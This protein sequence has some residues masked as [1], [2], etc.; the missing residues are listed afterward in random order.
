MS[1]IVN[2]R[3]FS[4]YPILAMCYIGHFY[5]NFDLRFH[6]FVSKGHFPAYNVFHTRFYYR[7]FILGSPSARLQCCDTRH[8]GITVSKCH[9]VFGTSI[10]TKIPY[11]THMC[12]N[13]RVPLGILYIYSYKNTLCHS[14]VL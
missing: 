14:L 8:Y 13:Q 1:F 5:T 2:I 3:H 12:Y 7:Y 11:V 4:R 10:H 6:L 9:W